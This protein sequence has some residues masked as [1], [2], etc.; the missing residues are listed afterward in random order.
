[1]ER[2]SGFFFVVSPRILTI[3]LTVF[4]P[5]TANGFIESVDKKKKFSNDNSWF[6][7]KKI[8]EDLSDPVS[9]IPSE[10]LMDSI[11]ENMLNIPEELWN[12]IKNESVQS[13]T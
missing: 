11:P 4:F 13:G 10:I 6:F 5:K 2:S 3:R 12:Q 9:S 1:M 7:W 8:P